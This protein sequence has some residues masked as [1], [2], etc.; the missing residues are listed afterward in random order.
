MTS[1]RVKQ[2]LRACI[3]YTGNRVVPRIFRPS[4]EG[5]F[6]C[7]IAGARRAGRTA[8]HQSGCSQMHMVFWLPAAASGAQKAKTD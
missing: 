6:F 3:F 2:T 8:W 7:E 4:S 5:R 1:L